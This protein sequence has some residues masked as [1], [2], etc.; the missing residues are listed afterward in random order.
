MPPHVFC[1]PRRPRTS[2]YN[3]LGR[4]GDNDISS[5]YHTMDLPFDGTFGPVASHQDGLARGGRS[6]HFISRVLVRGSRLQ[7]TQHKVQDG[8]EC[9]GWWKSK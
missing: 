6:V 5:H 4:D 9:S 3:A 8:H 1:A 2:I 7:Y